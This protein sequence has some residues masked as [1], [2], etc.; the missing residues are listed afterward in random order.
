MLVLLLVVAAVAAVRGLWSPCGLSMLSALNPVAERARGHR[1][2]STA[3]WYI[4]GSVAGGALL[5]AG[6]A[7]GAF[8]VERLG[9]SDSVVWTA[10]LV[11]GSVAALSDAR[12]GGWSLPVHPRQVNVRWLTAYRRWIYAGGFGVQIGTGFATYIMT[13]AV[14]LTALVA[15]LSGAPVVALVGGVMF[16]LVRGMCIAV[17]APARDPDRLAALLTRVESLAGASAIAAGFTCAGVAVVAGW[18]VGG[19]V[20]SAGAA[21]VLALAVVLDRVDARPSTERLVPTSPAA[22]RPSRPTAEP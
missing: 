4:A 15:V 5:G 6:C 10:V 13:A 3:C 21:L 18:L 11:G 14:Y 17:A 19:V 22:R 1:F 9:P 7:A 8:A 2:G 16:G 20:V 12:I